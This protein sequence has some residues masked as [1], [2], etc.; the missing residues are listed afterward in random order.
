M[1][2]NNGNTTLHS[3]T[4]SVVLMIFPSSFGF[5][6]QTAAS[7]TFQLQSFSED[8]K[9]VR[10]TAVAEF[11]QAVR[12]LQAQG[13]QVVVCPSQTDVDTPDAIFPNNWIS[14]HED[15]VITYPMLTPNRRNERQLENVE[16]VLEKA[17]GFA[18]KSHLDLSSLE[19]QGKILEGTGS[20]VLD[21]E[22]KVAF[23]TLSA[24]TTTAAIEIFTEKTGFSV[25]TFRSFD[26]KNKEIY[27]TNV[28]MSLGEEF[29]V[30]CIDAITDLSEKEKV[31]RKLKKLGKEIIAISL[32]QMHAFCGNILQ[33][34]NSDGNFKIAMSATAES[35][36]SESQL[37][38]LRKHGEF[39]VVDIPT[40]EVVGG[41]GIRCML[42][43]VF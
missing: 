2:N 34:K 40:V 41:G 43:E 13:I 33:L 30:I 16:A 24:R 19:N 37:T 5:N 26:Q 17:V 31:I 25:V 39:I 35:A 8:E 9:K 32:E 4:T 42:A 36:F 38:Q 10:D 27:H 7:N 6:T 29:A 1:P 22:N 23:A 12:A 3:Q 15:S 28:M 21:R 11:E 20:L 14:F 18:K